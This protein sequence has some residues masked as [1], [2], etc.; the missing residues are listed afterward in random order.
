LFVDASA[1][2]A[3]LNAED[4]A[5]D[6]EARMDDHGGPFFVSPLVRFEA[7]V[8]LARARRRG[9]E[10]RAGTLALAESAVNEFIAALQAQEIA[11]DATMGRG[12]LDAAKTFG[13]FVGHPAGLNFGD[14]YAYACAKTIGAPL[15]YK[16]RDFALTDVNRA[17]EPGP[18]GP[19]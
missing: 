13:K 9:N 6:L 8:G 3:I 7:V 19:A 12:A 1:V 18:P 5:T 4:D 15:L 14:C 2:I 16:G 17:F 11:I 10:Y